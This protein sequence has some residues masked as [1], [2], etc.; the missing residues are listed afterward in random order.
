MYLARET[1]RIVG[2]WDNWPFGQWDSRCI[3]PGGIDGW[4][5]GVHV[6]IVWRDGWNRVERH[7]K[8]P[9]ERERGRGALAE[10]GNSSSRERDRR[11]AKAGRTV[12]WGHFDLFD[13]FSLQSLFSS[14][15]S[16]GICL[17]WQ[18]CN[19]CLETFHCALSRSKA[20]NSVEQWPLF[21]TFICY[22]IYHRYKKLRTI[23]V[24]HIMNLFEL[25]LVRVCFSS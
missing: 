16:W 11:G 25:D 12:L 21:V 4:L 18:R 14:L 9:R 23:V 13:L 5:T 2:Q 1:I 8:R 22:S 24:V 19:S 10:W 7:I 17:S 3:L 20:V 6:S 15:Q